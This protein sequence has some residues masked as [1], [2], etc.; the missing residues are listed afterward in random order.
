MN[1]PIYKVHILYMHKYIETV[2]HMPNVKLL[3]WYD[4][5]DPIQ[6]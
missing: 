6:A 5:T 2:F 1:N 4:V 3:C